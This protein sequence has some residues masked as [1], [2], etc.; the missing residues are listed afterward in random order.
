MPLYIVEKLMGGIILLD[1]RG[2]ITLGR[3]TEAFRRKIRELIDAGYKRLIL[4]L[5]EI[6]YIDS[7]GL[8]TLVAS[9]TSVRKQGGDLKLLRLPQGVH[10]L[11]QITRL[12]TVFEIHNSLESALQAFD[13]EAV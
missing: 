9:L 8:G 12:V 6:T 7:V 3:E 10:Q 11:L 1:M 2:R 13:R 4:D 5:G